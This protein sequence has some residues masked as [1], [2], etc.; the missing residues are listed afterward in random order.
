VML[1]VI[2]GEGG[3]ILADKKWLQQLQKICWQKKVLLIID[4]VQTGIGRTGTFYAFEQYDLDPDI[5]TLAKGLANGIPVGAMLG[6]KKLAAAFGPGSYGTTS[7][8][9]K[10]ALASAIDV[11]DY[12]QENE[13]LKEVQAKGAYLLQQLKKISSSKIQD[14]RG[15]GLMVGIELTFDQPVEKILTDLAEVGVLALYAGHNTLRLLPALTITKKELDFGIEKITQILTQ[16][17]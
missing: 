6:K 14:I 17:Y 4:E 16:E 7:G 10:L 5:I 9:N 12:Y 3:V 11:L 1:E 2:Q 13:L 15:K 8:G